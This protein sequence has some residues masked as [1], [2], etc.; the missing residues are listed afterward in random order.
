MANTKWSAFPNGTVE[1]GAKVAGLSVLGANVLFETDDILPGQET[2]G[3]FGIR[4]YS[5]PGDFA[6]LGAAMQH[7]RD[8]PAM[9]TNPGFSPS[10]IIM[11]LGAGSHAGTFSAEGLGYSIRINGDDRTTTT[12]SGNGVQTLMSAVGSSMII[13]GAEIS[14]GVVTTSLNS[15]MW[16]G[17]D[18]DAAGEAITMDGGTIYVLNNSLVEVWQMDLTTTSPSDFWLEDSSTLICRQSMTFTNF[19]PNKVWQNSHLR[20]EGDLNINM[21]GVTNNAMEVEGSVVVTGNVN[22]T[23]GNDTLV[24]I[25]TSPGARMSV[26]GDINL[27]G[28]TAEADIP[29]N[30]PQANGSV[31]WVGAQP[32][33]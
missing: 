33:P 13:T 11:N 23:G 10:E 29:I 16:L 20:V 12:I 27:T 18:Q 26:G 30:V 1:S 19:S 21:T 24:A 6:T 2:T 8:F 25:L 22:I 9:A 15:T 3:N 17:N 4:Q 32:I 7:A 14:Y 5:I 28:Y 31:I